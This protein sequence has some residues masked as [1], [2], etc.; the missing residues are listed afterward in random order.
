[1]IRNLRNAVEWN[2]RNAVDKKLK[3]QVCLGP[4][5]FH[6]ISSEFDVKFTNNVSLRSRIGLS[7]FW[8]GAGGLGMRRWGKDEKFL[9]HFFSNHIYF[10][11]PY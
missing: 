5:Y 2:V 11:A 10:Q 7:G 6:T 9:I 3:C 1:M 4:V 8:M